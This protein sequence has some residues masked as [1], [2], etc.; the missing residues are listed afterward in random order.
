MRSKKQL[1]E[2]EIETA[3]LFNKY[4]LKIPRRILPKII[5]DW[6]KPMDC[7]KTRMRTLL[8]EASM[9]KN[10][11]VSDEGRIIVERG[12]QPALLINNKESLL[13]EQIKER[14]LKQGIDLKSFSGDINWTK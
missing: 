5:F 9:D 1:K 3:K 14:L 13:S 10:F 4:S 12:E 2:L 7:F 6:M 8:S 11:E